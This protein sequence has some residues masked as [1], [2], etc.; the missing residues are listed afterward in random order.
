[1][2]PPIKPG[3]WPFVGNTWAVRQLQQ[4]VT[5]DELSHALLITGPDSVGKR[6]LA[7]ILTAA[8]LCQA[9]VEQRPC[10]TC[11]SCRKLESGNQPDF[12]LVEPE[13]KGKALVVKQIRDL[14][15][16]LKL[17]PI[18]SVCK[19]ALVNDFEQANESA[20]NALLKTLEEPPS[21]VRL[22]LLALDADLVLPTIVS[23]SQQVNLRPTTPQKIAEAL[24]ARW[25]VE[26]ETAQRLARLSGGR[27]GWAVRAAT[28][29]AHLET[30]TSALQLLFDLIR[31]DLPTRFE[32]AETLAKDSAQFA[33]TLEYWRIAWRDV[34]LLQTE[35]DD[36][37][38]YQEHRETLA[39]LAQRQPLPATLA[40]LKTLASAQ[41]ALRRYV[42][43]RLL[44]ESLMLELPGLN[45]R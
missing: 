14:E 42:N 25:D 10:G 20:A 41:A 7:R 24:V 44:A 31:Q 32:A 19:I 16:F 4:A 11:L 40:L 33:E 26:P 8:L 34:L 30:Q 43:A 12:M 1:M 15:R 21:H 22:I 3:D 39:S 2:T 28:D 5:R 23:R 35:A 45:F 6:A 27:M 17:T 18:E 9:P 36:A 38:T 29:P 13:Q 37:V